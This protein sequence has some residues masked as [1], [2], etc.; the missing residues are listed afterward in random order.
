MAA[1]PAATPLTQAEY[2]ALTRDVLARI[3][4][5][6]DAWLQNDVVDIDG[7]RT[8]GLLEL[9]LP[10][11]SQVIVNTQPPLQE[12]W[13]AARAGGRHFRYVRPR[14][15]DTRDGSEFFAV[16]SREL[17]AQ[18]GTALRVEPVAAG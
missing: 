12:L 10:G 18:A 13:L 8:G 6:L 17:S 14:W 2:D 15:V 5:A 16:L 4:S 7:H 3:E 1:V 9:T 11:G